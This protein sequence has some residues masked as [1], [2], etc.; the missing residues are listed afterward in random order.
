M[1]K[2]VGRKQTVRNAAKKLSGSSRRPHAARPI[3]DDQWQGTPFIGI[4]GVRVS[5]M[6]GV[7]H[8]L[9]Q[10]IESLRS[11]ADDLIDDPL[12]EGRSGLEN[13]LTAMGVQI[14]QYIALAEGYIA[15]G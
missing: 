13:K 6:G 8:N 4:G 12:D 5:C 7:L 14:G 1:K 3:H 11:I 10:G 2:S 9:T 15:D